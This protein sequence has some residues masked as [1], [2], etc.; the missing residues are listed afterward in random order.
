MKKFRPTFLQVVSLL[1]TFFLFLCLSGNAQQAAPQQGGTRFDITNY[2]I[3]AQIIP[4]QLSC[5]P[6]PT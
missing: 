4:D 5:E 6:E 3:E 2:R 1:A